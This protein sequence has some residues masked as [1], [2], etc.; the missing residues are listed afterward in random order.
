MA[1]GREN[2]A[3]TRQH[4]AVD[5]IL[6]TKVDKLSPD[7]VV[8]GVCRELV[9]RAGTHIESFDGKTLLSLLKHCVKACCTQLAR[10]KKL[11]RRDDEPLFGNVLVS[12]RRKNGDL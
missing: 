9:N 12:R 3:M 6:T 10:T 5:G 2:R 1:I 11:R 7:S 8:Y 4:L